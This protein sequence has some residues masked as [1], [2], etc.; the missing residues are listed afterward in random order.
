MRGTR[1]RDMGGTTYF[2]I[3]SSTY[4]DSHMR[5]KNTDQQSHLCFC[6][7]LWLELGFVCEREG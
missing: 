5:R 1:R 7:S 3:G 4:F 6:A 2:D